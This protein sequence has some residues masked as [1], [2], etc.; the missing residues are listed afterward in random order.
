MVARKHIFYVGECGDDAWVYH[1]QLLI[2][3]HLSAYLYFTSLH[4]CT[5]RRQ[6]LL[7]LRARALSAPAVLLMTVGNG[8]YRVSSFTYMGNS[9]RRRSNA[10]EGREGIGGGV[11]GSI[12]YRYYTWSYLSSR[13]FT[14]PFISF[15][16]RRYSP[17][18]LY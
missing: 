2:C 1:I 14:S 11:G 16:P 8:A 6:A 9:A 5:T 3:V 17:F 7:F 15:H 12:A 13:C 18:D 4:I 10:Q